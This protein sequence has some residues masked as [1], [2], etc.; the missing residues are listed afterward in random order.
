MTAKEALQLVHDY[1]SKKNDAEAVKLVATAVKAVADLGVAASF[2]S[3]EGVA[4]AVKDL[5]ATC[6]ACHTAHREKTA[7]GFLIK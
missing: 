2:S 5:G 6:A 1:W 7:D 3:G 4:A